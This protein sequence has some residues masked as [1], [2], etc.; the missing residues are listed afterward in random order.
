MYQKTM[1]TL[2]TALTLALLMTLGCDDSTVDAGR[3]NPAGDGDGD[4][5]H[6]ADGCGFADEELVEPLP[7]GAW[8]DCHSPASCECKPTFGFMCD[9]GWILGCDPI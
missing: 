3:R 8:L 7:P 9:E 1:K 4:G 5:G 2:G 6:M